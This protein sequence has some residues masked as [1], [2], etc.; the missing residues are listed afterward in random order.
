MKVGIITASLPMDTRAALRKAK[1]LGAHGVQLWIVNND[2]D[3][4]NLTKSGREELITYMA[5]LGLERS[6]LCGDIGGFADPAKLDERVARTKEMFDLCV[7]LKTPV[8]TTH[9]GVLPEEKAA[10]EAMLDGIKELA[11]YAA[12]RDCCFA[13]ETGLESGE[14]LA[15]FLREVGSDGARVN[16]DPAN[17]CM[18]G[19][20]HLAAVRDLAPYIVHTHA[21][22]GIYCSARQGGYKEVPLGKGDVNFPKYLE[23]L[24]EIGYD[25]YLTI[26]RECGADPVAD[27]AEAIRFLKQFPGVEK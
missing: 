26:E 13:T 6:A 12:N 21:K 14:G 4:R 1:E 10:Y 23:T 5:S 8:L 11:E 2:L 22:D 7:D 27:I 18:N 25:G 24:R 3:P 20:D 17:L 9:I 19:Y 15:K 16:F